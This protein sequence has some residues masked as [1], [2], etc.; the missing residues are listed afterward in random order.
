M[1]LITASRFNVRA[2]SCTPLLSLYCNS[3]S[4]INA[5][6]LRVLDLCLSLIA[7]FVFAVPPSPLQNTVSTV[8]VDRRGVINVSWTAPAVPTGELPITGYSIRY[9]IRGS[10]V[11]GYQS[12]SVVKSPS[13]VTGLLPGSEYQV[14][15]AS[16]N[17]I[18]AGLYCCVGT[19][20]YVTTY[21]GTYLAS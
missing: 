1:L 8:P 17:A 4:C 21:S 11:S 2:Y 20:S 7:D 18:G 16:V 3:P 13:E 19:P 10:G 15:V 12:K 6:K 14:Y 9:H 5:C